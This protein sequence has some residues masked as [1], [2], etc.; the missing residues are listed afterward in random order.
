MNF[1][2]TINPV[3]C[4]KCHHTLWPKNFDWLRRQPILP[5]HCPNCK[6]DGLDEPFD[7]RK[8]P[9][10]NHKNTLMA[11]C[12]LCN[13]NFICRQAWLDYAKKLKREEPGRENFMPRP[14]KND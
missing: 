13:I 1:E 6:N 14:I 12:P 7:K 2:V 5:T 9:K 10:L 3:H 8:G 11:H 4:R